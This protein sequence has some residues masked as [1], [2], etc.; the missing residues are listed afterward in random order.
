MQTESGKKRKKNTGNGVRKTQT[1]GAAL[2]GSRW[3]WMDNK[4]QSEW[5]WK[6]IKKMLKG[7]KEHGVLAAQGTP[8]SFIIK[9]PLLFYS[10]SHYCLPFST[11][12]TCHCMKLPGLAAIKHTGR[13]TSIG[14]KRNGRRN[15]IHIRLWRRK[16]VLCIN[17]NA[18][19]TFVSVWCT[20][21]SPEIPL[22][23]EGSQWTSGHW[24]TW[25]SWCS[26]RSRQENMSA[27]W[28]GQFDQWNAILKS[29]IWWSSKWNESVWLLG[30]RECYIFIIKS[31]SIING[32]LEVINSWNGGEK[33]WM[34]A[35]TTDSQTD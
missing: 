30:F 5:K 9:S 32:L 19:K 6:T 12:L 31:L 34:S 18:N 26:W 23:C 28:L 17:I 11:I 10:L 16:S 14:W 3:R 24:W 25:I 20:H 22:Q 8:G 7:K 13:T 29:D 21:S 15:Q 1:F 4:Q 2:Q 33:A 27:T 35:V